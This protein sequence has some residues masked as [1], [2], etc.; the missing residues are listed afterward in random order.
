MISLLRTRT[1]IMLAI[2]SGLLAQAQ[3]PPHTRPRAPASPHR[4]APVAVPQLGDEVPELLLKRAASHKPCDVGSGKSDPCT[5]LVSGRDRITV[6]WDTSTH[7]VTFLYST[8]L[9]TD[10]DIRAGDLLAIDPSSPITPFPTADSP[11]RFV[12]VDW[13]DTDHDVSAEATWCAV[14]VPVR[15]RSGK[16]LGFVQTLYLYLPEF[17]PEPMHRVSLQPSARSPLRARLR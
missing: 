17:D 8:T 4:A 15:P 9:Q 12:T 14:M 3:S 6:A 10:D 5:T 16:V 2:S 11:H 13:C 7:H 1:A